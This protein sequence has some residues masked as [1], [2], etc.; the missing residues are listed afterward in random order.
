MNLY[1]A[2]AKAHMQEFRPIQYAQIPDKDAYFTEVGEEASR[3]VSSMLERIRRP[4]MEDD[5][6]SMLMA[7]ESVADLL[8]PPAEEGPEDLVDQQTV[9]WVTDQDGED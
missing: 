9:P 4:G 5:P 7:E 2:K 3:Q 6:M 8:F 1:G